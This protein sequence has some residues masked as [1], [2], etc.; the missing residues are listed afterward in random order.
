MIRTGSQVLI[1]CLVTLAFADGALAYKQAAPTVRVTVSR[2]GH[3]YAKSVPQGSGGETR[4]YRVQAGQDQLWFTLS[5]VAYP[6][7]DEL[8]TDEPSVAPQ[9]YIT[10]GTGGG[11]YAKSVPELNGT[12][13]VTRVYRTKAAEDLLIQTYPW[14]SPHLALD[15]WFAGNEVYVVR[16]GL[17]DST[18][19]DGEHTLVFHKNDKLLKSYSFSALSDLAKKISGTPGES[20]RIRAKQFRRPFG[21]Q[22]IFDIDWIDGTD[23]AFNVETG[24]A[25][26]PD[27]E[28]LLEQ[29]YNA[30]KQI[31]KLQQAWHDQ[32]DDRRHLITEDE[33]R[34]IN[35]EGFPELPHGYRYVPGLFWEP[36]V[37]EKD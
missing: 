6:D 3:Y 19:T 21:N 26:T 2:F 7:V 22:L 8:V 10:T 36:V 16:L 34:A 14:Y 30:K 24:E 9:P 4:V 25:V 17:D 31:S 1:G 27:E 28:A 37:L 20:I 13:G 23:L 11:F 29:L 35:P 18:V 5:F 12:A 33:L 15:G 32:H